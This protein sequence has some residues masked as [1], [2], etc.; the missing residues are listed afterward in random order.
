MLNVKT[1]EGKIMFSKH[2]EE[3]EMTTSGFYESTLLDSI[4][5]FDSIKFKI[6][7]VKGYRYIILVQMF[8]TLLK[9][10]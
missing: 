10:M 5:F 1:I 2:N 9:I 8:K 3:Q 7:N 6:W 4:T